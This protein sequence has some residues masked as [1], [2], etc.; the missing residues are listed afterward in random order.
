MLDAMKC[1]HDPV[2]SSC[3]DLGPH[4]PGTKNWLIPAIVVPLL[5]VSGLL[6]FL[7]T[8]TTLRYKLM[9]FCGQKNVPGYEHEIVDPSEQY[10]SL[11]HDDI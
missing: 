7:F 4:Q 8:K 5:A 10:V 2:P 9:H 11:P 6:L 3:D 1:R